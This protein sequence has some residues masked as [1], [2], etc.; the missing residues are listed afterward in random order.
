MVPLHPRHLEQ[1]HLRNGGRSSTAVHDQRGHDG[2]VQGILIRNV[3][4][5]PLRLVTFT[6][7]PILSMLVL[8]MSHPDPRPEHRVT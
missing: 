8:M 7:P 3:V 1:V 6:V 2:Q 5:S 4:P